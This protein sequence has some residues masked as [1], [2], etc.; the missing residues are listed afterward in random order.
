MSQ[1]RLVDLAILGIDSSI[2]LTINV[3]TG[4][5]EFKAGAVLF[6]NMNAQFHPSIHWSMGSTPVGVQFPLTF[7]LG[8]FPD[9]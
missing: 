6:K 5:R 9:Y 4:I 7:S 3:D 1:E 8:E 2:V